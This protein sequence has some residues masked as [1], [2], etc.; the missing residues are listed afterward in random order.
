[1]RRSFIRIGPLSVALVLGLSLCHIL[2]NLAPFEDAFI[3][4]RYAQNFADGRGLVFNP[5]ERVEGF[6]S[7]LFTLLLATVGKLHLPIEATS[8]AL[9]AAF[10]LATVA[11]TAELHAVFSS[12]DPE[13]SEWTLGSAAAALLVA[14]DGSF[15]YFAGTGLESSLFFLLLVLALAEAARPDRGIRTGVMLGAL[16]LVR[17]EG[18]GYAA[19]VI[20]AMGFERG[21][22]RNAGR[23][24]LITVAVVAPLFVFRWRHFG[25]LLPNTYYAK[26][27]S[28]SSAAL[29]RGL[30]YTEGFVTSHLFWASI[31]A[32][33]AL[34]VLTRGEVRS[35]LALAVVGGAL[36]S[37]IASGGDTFN[38]FRFMVP[39]VPVGAVALVIVWDRYVSPRVAGVR[40][41]LAPALAVLAL[42][43][44]SALVLLAENVPVD[45]FR[46]RRTMSERE[47][48]LEV[49]KINAEYRVVGAWLAAHVPGGS[50]LAT[51]AVGIVPWTSRLPTVDMLGLTDAHIAHTDRPIGHGAVGHEKHDGAYVL[52]RRPDVI[53]F[54]LPR[55]TWREPSPAG[56]DK[57]VRRLFPFLPGDREIYESPT[58]RANYEPTVAHTSGGFLVLFVRR[59]VALRP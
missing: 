42:L 23:A 56:V 15:A 45:T 49:A 38:Y 33:L 36:G 19:L 10:G 5:G 22:A 1:M 16:A 39:A 46:M 52:A 31:A 29:L 17:P 44:L 53:L 35:R 34:V 11:A 43:C 3:T 41:A 55:L 40:A 18:L 2:W 6:S 47:K 9:S 57:R 48:V 20:L 30:D 26:G 13:R 12:D 27:A 4:Y 58:F 25:H 32:V 51:N 7:F 14:V 21:R 8:R 54:G 28:K 59:G 24:A 50:L 37:S